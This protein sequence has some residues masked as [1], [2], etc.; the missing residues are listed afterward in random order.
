MAIKEPEGIT[1]QI[2]QASRLGSLGFRHV[3]PFRIVRYR[4][5]KNR[6][7]VLRLPTLLVYKNYINMLGP[8]EFRSR[9]HC[10]CYAL[11]LL[12]MHHH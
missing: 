10:P 9:T 2:V 12:K 8:P 6:K 5:P 11:R 7:E 1:L 4:D 3:L